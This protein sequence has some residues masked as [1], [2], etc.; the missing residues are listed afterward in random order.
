MS[1]MSQRLDLRQSQSLV[2]TPQLQQAIKLLQMSNIELQDFVATELESNPLLERDDPKSDD[3]GSAD[4]ASQP[5]QSGSEDDNGDVWAQDRMHLA[6]PAT[7]GF[8]DD[9]WSAVE[10][11]SNG[12]SLRDHLTQQLMVDCVEA[13]E[14]MIGSAL[15]ELVDDAGYLP[16]DLEL[17]RTQLG[18]TPAQFQGTIEKL[19]R[20]DPPGIFARNLKECLA[21]QL[22]DK[23]RLDP[24]M[25]AMLDHLDLVAR[26]DLQRLQRICGVDAED[27][28][29][30]LA[31]IRL[32]NPKP[33]TAFEPDQA[34][35]VIPDVLLRPMTGGGWHVELNAE[36]LPRVLVNERYYAQIKDGAKKIA[37]K[38]Y[39]SD[40][41]Q[42]ANWLIKALAQRQET[43][44]KVATEIVRRQDDFF[45]YGVSHLK[46]MILRDI[47]EAVEMHESTISRVTSH[48]YIATPRGM[49]ELKYF[50]S[51]ALSSTTGGEAVATEAVRHKIKTLIENERPESVLSDDQL[52]MLL[53][54]EGIDIA[55]RTVAKYRESLGIQTSAVRKRQKR[56][57]H[58]TSE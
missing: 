52:A 25:Q 46:P 10:Q 50:F 55:R 58:C 12:T 15:I 2:M 11:I 45:T 5:E 28:T 20:F 21:L 35:P 47:A 43:I 24:A 14:R 13:A 34:T 38:N 53:K 41:W 54:G 44:L 36:T 40:R 3:T 48:K 18:A 30:M 51:N 22:R 9:D 17:V 57:A 19:Q 29:D 42:Q 26:N 32:L 16:G 33:A 8:Q 49:F 31:E 56:G 23:N 37:D 39:V 1:Q 27:I 4:S 6:Q 7:R